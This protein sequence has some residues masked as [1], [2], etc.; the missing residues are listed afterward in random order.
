MSYQNKQRYNNNNRHNNGNFRQRNG[1]PTKAGTTTNTDWKSINITLDNSL[2]KISFCDKECFNINNNQTKDNIVSYVQSKFKI[3][4]IEREYVSLNP[5]MLRNISNHEHFL[6]T[7]SNGNPYLI[8]F[9]KIDG[10]NCSI[11]IDRKLKDGYSYPKIHLVQYD[12]D[13]H[14]F[15]TDMI[16]TGELV[17]DI[18]REWCYLISD[19]I[20]YEGED[21]T[22]TKNVL[23]R[24]NLLYSVLDK[25]YKPN[26]SIESCPLYVKKLWQYSDMDTIFDEYMPSLSYICKGLVFYTMNN[27]FSNYAW[28]MPRDRQIRVKPAKEADIAFYE[29]Y[30]EYKEIGGIVTSENTLEQT[31]GSEQTYYANAIFTKHTSDTIDT[32]DSENTQ[33]KYFNSKIM[34]TNML[35]K[36]EKCIKHMCQE[37]SDSIDDNIIYK[38]FQVIKTSNPGIYKCLDAN[39]Q[40]CGILYIPYLELDKELYRLFM[41]DDNNT[42]VEKIKMKCLYYEIFDKWIPVAYE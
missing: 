2:N 3:K 41:N 11:F 21:I 17:R 22:K 26:P 20:I 8:W 6:A 28:L 27:Q 42:K 32:I 10:N 1:I 14:I 12:I 13:D 16:V 31:E 35:K 37:N 19:L 5:H 23:S 36:I 39:L 7:Y 15:E 30:P 25:Y 33:W 9:T 38:E 29:Q 34:I 40:D 4:I 18:N 24:F